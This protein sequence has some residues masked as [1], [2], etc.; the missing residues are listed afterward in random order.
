MRASRGAGT[1]AIEAVSAVL[2]PPDSVCLS[3]RHQQVESA[4]MVLRVAL[5]TGCTRYALNGL[6]RLLNQPVKLLKS[7]HGGQQ[8][9]LRL[10]GLAF[11]LVG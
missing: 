9:G 7:S 11:S 3:L 2:G 1:L 8:L 5:W 10:Q 6:T 4:A